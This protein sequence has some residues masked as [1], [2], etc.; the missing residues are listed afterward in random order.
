MKTQP[1]EIRALKLPRSLTATKAALIDLDVLACADAMLRQAH[2]DVSIAVKPRA[3]MR[4]VATVYNL[5]IARRIRSQNDLNCFLI[6]ALRADDA[7][8]G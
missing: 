7:A 1:P 3:R 2:R 8:G 4:M 6:N 5:I